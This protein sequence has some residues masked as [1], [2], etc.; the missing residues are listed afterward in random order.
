[1][2]FVTFVPFV[3]FVPLVPLGQSLHKHPL[4]RLCPT[5]QRC[6]QPIAA[7]ALTGHDAHTQ[8]PT[9]ERGQ[10]QHGGCAGNRSFN[11]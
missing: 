11:A 8:E 5:M 10:I 1:V 6:N 4:K 7:L 2:V 3:P 9:A